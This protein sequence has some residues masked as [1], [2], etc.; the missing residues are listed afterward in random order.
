MLNV[1][2]LV[3][4]TINLS[5][6]AAQGR[7]FGILM[8]AGDSNVINGVERFRE[9]TTID[10][11]SADFG[12]TAPETLAAELY[13]SQVPQPS[14]CF[15]GA[16]LRTA[17]AAEN[18][19]GI[20]SASEQA[21]SNWNAISNGAFNITIDG[22]V[23]TLTGLNFNGVTNLNGV[24]TVVNS[25]LTGGTLIF[26]GTKFVMKSN[27][28]GIGIQ[29]TGT[30]TFGSNPSASD[31]ITVDGTLITFVA[32]SPTGSEVLI[33]VDANATAG[34]LYTFLHNSVD[35][36]ISK[37]NYTLATNVVDVAFKTV[38]TTGNAFTLAKSSTAITLS[39]ST[40]LGGTVPSSV[41]FATSGT[42]TDISAQLKLT[43]STAIAL[44][45]GFA[46]ETP[47]QCATAL[48]SISSGW[49]GLNFAASVMPTDQQNLDVAPFIQ[50]LVVKR[51]F[52]ITI[53][54]TNVLSAQVTNDLASLLKAAG[55]TRTTTQYSST[56]PY[57]VT[58]M[59]GRAFSVDFTAQNSVITL[60]YKQEPGIVP[61]DLSDQEASV[62][63]DKRCNVYASYDNGTNVLQYGTMAGPAYFDEIHG[64]DWFE[65]DL[66]TEV[67]NVLYL[68]P[69]KIP[70]TDSGVNKL[71]NACGGSCGDA[72]NNGL[73][74]PGVWN[75]PSFGTLQ[76]GQYLKTGFYIFAESVDLQSQADR[77]ARKAPPIQIALKLAGAIQTVDV[78]VTVNR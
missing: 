14:T 39:A 31:T 41:N 40:L 38:G 15:I 76:T 13:F 64:L 35:V 71:V 25:S 33:G 10:G 24:A 54:N 59:F 56:N 11:I 18:E 68:T 62:L 48:A 63:Q 50:S 65:N 44:I 6:L 4:V 30:I 67:F 74:A 23:K 5:P 37:A 58:S 12:S 49:Y 72:V 73:A 57:A 60:M 69:T 75:G 32:A 34:N 1:S 46:A 20:L 45:P 8:I 17:Q 3:K 61:E 19:G 47:L 55:Y 9:Y 53:Q 29:A 27:T 77:D 51:I 16:W 21:I 70:Q 22:V 2:R 52:G 66:Q 78:L 42:G 28:T 36:N 43:S 26:D 7:S